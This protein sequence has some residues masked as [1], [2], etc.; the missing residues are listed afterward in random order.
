MASVNATRG[1]M[2][3]AMSDAVDGGRLIGFNYSGEAC[4]WY[5]GHS[6]HV[7]DAARDWSEVRMFTSGQL[8]AI[9]D[10][11]TPEATE[12]AKQRIRSEGFQL[13]E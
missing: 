3:Q 13:V 12:Y 10:H 2:N 4:V 1:A 11:E 8:M 6:F 5:G 7:Y 9:T